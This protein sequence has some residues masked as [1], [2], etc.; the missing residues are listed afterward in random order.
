MYYTINTLSCVADSHRGW[1]K[2]P[3]RR[4]VE[5]NPIRMSGETRRTH[6]HFPQPS[7]KVRLDSPLPETHPSPISSFL[8][9]KIKI[10]IRQNHLLMSSLE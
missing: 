4:V 2:D 3:H 10:Y 5:S 6:T 7:R 8:R 1:E 9:E